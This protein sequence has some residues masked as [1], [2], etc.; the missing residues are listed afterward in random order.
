M[1]ILKIFVVKILI[2]QTYFKPKQL[3]STLTVIV[4]S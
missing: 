1:I 2:C 3:I 4:D